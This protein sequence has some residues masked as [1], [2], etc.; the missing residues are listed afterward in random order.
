MALL[1]AGIT[2]KAVPACI[3]NLQVVCVVNAYVT[4]SDGGSNTISTELDGLQYISPA[5]PY[6]GCLNG[7]G[8]L[9]TFYIPNGSGCPTNTTK[10]A[11]VY[12][13][14][15]GASCGLNTCSAGQHGFAITVPANCDSVSGQICSELGCCSLQWEPIFSHPCNNNA[16]QVVEPEHKLITSK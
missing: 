6:G 2:A 13:S 15:S 8:P 7:T 3:T 12:Y 5:D 10:V 9:L 16:C 11:I 4:V 1:V 14:C